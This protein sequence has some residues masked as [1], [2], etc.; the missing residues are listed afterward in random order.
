[1]A[2]LPTS[3]M[4]NKIDLNIINVRN[5]FKTTYFVENAQIKIFMYKRV[6][7]Q[8]VSFINVSKKWHKKVKSSN[9]ARDRHFHKISVNLLMPTLTSGGR[10]KSASSSGPPEGDTVLP[11]GGP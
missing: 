3:G 8:L 5:L 4:S 11:P 2:N 7:I 1:M 9:I 10:P 6:K